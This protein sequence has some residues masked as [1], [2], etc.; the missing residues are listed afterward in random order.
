MY[1]AAVDNGME[2]LSSTDYEERELT[3]RL[4]SLAPLD[5]LKALKNLG[6]Y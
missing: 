1:C 3:R 5:P 6:V 2:L 4:G